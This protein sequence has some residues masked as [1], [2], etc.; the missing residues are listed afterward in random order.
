MIT[1]TV[2][3]ADISLSLIPMNNG[4]LL[5]GTSVML[6]C[7]TQISSSVNTNDI[8]VTINWSLHSDTFLTNSSKYTIHPVTKIS[9]IEYEDILEIHELELDDSTSPYTCTVSVTSENEHLSGT[10]TN[11]SITLGITGKRLRVMYNYHFYFFNYDNFLQNLN[12]KTW[13]L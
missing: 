3:D 11:E 2:P 4:S 13:I 10:S 5:E 12:H 7:S 6:N 9:S 8:D 1:F